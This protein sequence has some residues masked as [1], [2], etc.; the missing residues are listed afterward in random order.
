MLTRGDPPAPAPPRGRPPP[1][2]LP[3]PPSVLSAFDLGPKCPAWQGPISH[4]GRR[5]LLDCT[6][7]WQGALH[8]L[9]L[10]SLHALVAQPPLA[11]A[12][13]STSRL[14]GGLLCEKIWHCKKRP[15]RH[16]NSN[17]LRAK[18]APSKARNE[19]ITAFQWGRARAKMGSIN[20]ERELKKTTECVGLIGLNWWPTTS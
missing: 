16:Q 2:V 14:A 6:R 11:D 9:H 3:L 13:A 10:I 5:R 7:H 12:Q 4:D 8:G 20:S 17:F 18:P 1:S 19:Q 15:T